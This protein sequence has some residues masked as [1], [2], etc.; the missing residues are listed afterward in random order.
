MQGARCR[1]R[2]RDPGIT[3]WAEGKLSTTE[4]LRHPSHFF[5]TDHKNNVGLIPI[6]LHTSPCFLP[7]F[8]LIEI[9]CLPKWPQLIVLRNVNPWWFCPYGVCSAL[10]PLTIGRAVHKVSPR[11]MPPASMNTVLSPLCKSSPSCPWQVAPALQQSPWPLFFLLPWW[12]QD[13][14]MLT[15]TVPLLFFYPKN[16]RQVFT[17]VHMFVAALFTVAKR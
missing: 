3:P 6:L 17:C 12:L 14:E 1:T 16:W 10:L 8:R 9:L 13:S 2:S 5:A 11:G 15:Q 7:A 4:P